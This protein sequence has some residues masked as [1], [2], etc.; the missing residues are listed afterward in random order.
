MPPRPRGSRDPDQEAYLDQSVRAQALGL[1]AGGGRGDR[2][3]WRRVRLGRAGR[4]PPKPKAEE[5]VA[6]WPSPKA[7]QPERKKLSPGE[8]RDACVASYFDPG[9]LR[10]RAK[11]LVRLR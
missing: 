11:L 6:P 4:R 7:P 9:R 3:R 1:A 8:E 5:P 2:W 10:Q